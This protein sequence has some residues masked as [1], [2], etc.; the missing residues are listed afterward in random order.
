MRERPPIWIEQEGREPEGDEGTADG[1]LR[2]YLRDLTAVVS[3]PVLWR[4]RDPA[5]L[6][7]QLAEVLLGLLDLSRVGVSFSHPAVGSLESVRPLP[8]RSPSAALITGAPQDRIVVQPSRNPERWSVELTSPRTDFPTPRERHLAQVTTDLAAIA[9]ESALARAQVERALR[10]E[11]EMAQTIERIASSVTAEL[12]LDKVV[13]T[14]TDAATQLVGAQFGAF[15]YNVMDAD[16][17][18]YTLYT[19]SG[20]PR[21][22]FSRFPMPR[23]TAVFDPTFRGTGIMRSDDIRRDSR[24]GRNAPYHGMPEGHLPVVSYLAVPVVS[25]AGEVLG[26]LFF[27]HEQAGRFTERHEKLVVGIA[28]WAALAIDNARLY[29]SERVARAEAERA[30]AAKSEFLAAMSH[31]LRTPL[32]A[33]QGHVQLLEMGVHGPLEPKQRESLERVQKSQRHLL[34]LINDV[35]NF[36]KLEA[37]RVEF[38]IQPFAIAPLVSDTIDVMGAQFAGRGLTVEADLPPDLQVSADRD[39]V[40]QILLNLLSNALKFTEKGGVTITV[41]DAPDDSGLVRL[42][43]RDTGIGIA[44]DR[45]ANIFDPFVQAHRRLKRAEPGT[46]LGLTISRDLAR[47]MGGALLVTSEEGRGSTFELILRRHT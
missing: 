15:F 23:K 28:T 1:E 17:E 9:V 19:I 44:L 38:V 27:G 37:G 4:S 5:G 32:N 7:E 33:I 21:E 24:Y 43:V 14:V 26:G 41:A 42:M 20:V 3:L 29:Q 39:K 2:R 8:G 11:A 10:D 16:G 47:G 45:Q 36:A 18:S 46:G 22:R 30:N 25:R 35:L 40:H 12:S 34:A 6:V 13:Q 31:E